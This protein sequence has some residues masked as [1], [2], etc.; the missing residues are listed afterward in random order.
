M[1][2]LNIESNFLDLKYNIFPSMTPDNKSSQ[3]QTISDFHVFSIL[4]HTVFVSCVLDGEERI[5]GIIK[6]C[7]YTSE[8]FKQFVASS[9]FL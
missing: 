7:V 3:H 4:D 8:P 1:Y 6:V 2:C 5:N 9:D